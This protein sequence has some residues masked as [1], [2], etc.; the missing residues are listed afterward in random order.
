MR[1]ADYEGI[2]DFSHEQRQAL[3]FLYSAWLIPCEFADTWI[4]AL[5]DRG[6]A[7]ENLTAFRDAR[8]EAE[9]VVEHRIWQ[10]KATGTSTLKSSEETW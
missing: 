1:E 6:C 10:N 3:D 9:E 8:E 7:P 2:F 4:S 5:A